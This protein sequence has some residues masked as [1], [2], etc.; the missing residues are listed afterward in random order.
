TSSQR[1]CVDGRMK[2]DLVAPGVHI[3]G[4]APQNGAATLNGMG[5]GSSCFD[6]TGVCALPSGGTVGSRFNFFPLDQQFYTV[7]DGTSHAAPAVSGACA[8]LRQYFIN[9]SNSPPS[10]AATK[11]YLMNS[12]R[13]LTGA[14]ANDTLWSPRQGMG[15][16]NLGMAFDGV[17]RVVRD[18]L[19]AD[20]FTVTGQTRTFS[21]TIQDSS[22]PFRVT[23][24]WTDVPGST[25]AA[26][27][28]V[29]DL[30][31]TVT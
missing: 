12:A 3:T 28:L 21:G 2:P 20:T 16:L 11:A 31:L 29:N 10:P 6:G 14:Y 5:R 1:P 18:Q 15:E 23:L 30:D 13:Y 24:A 22:K 25:V 26:K 17:P 8:L 4:G 27:A 7:S 9:Q 19:P